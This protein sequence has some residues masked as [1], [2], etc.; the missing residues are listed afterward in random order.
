MPFTR[1]GFFGWCVRSS[2]EELVELVARVDEGAHPGR[3]EG[4]AD[5]RQVHRD[6]VPERDRH[7]LLELI[8]QE[9][10]ECATSDGCN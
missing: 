7:L 9:L 2:S 5:R 10:L 8:G 6:A 4:G 3:V 1:S